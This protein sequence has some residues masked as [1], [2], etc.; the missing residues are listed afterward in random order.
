MTSLGEVLGVA[1]ELIHDVEQQRS[2]AEI[3]LG[4][5]LEAKRE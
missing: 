5:E 1:H 4:L 2:A 3:L